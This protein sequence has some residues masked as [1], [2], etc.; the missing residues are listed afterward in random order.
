MV[1]LILSISIIFLLEIPSLL[2]NQMWRE[3]M[4]FC[5]I[6]I[7]GVTY[8]IIHTFQLQFLNPTDITQNIFEPLFDTVDSLLK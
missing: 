1:L 7:I 8:G 3:L 5:G 2:K 4:V 6:L